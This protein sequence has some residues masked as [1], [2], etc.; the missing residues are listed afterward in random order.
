MVRLGSMIR[1]AIRLDAMAQSGAPRYS[2]IIVS[3][4]VSLF[5]IGLE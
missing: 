3:I 1:R 5:H 4:Y 2:K